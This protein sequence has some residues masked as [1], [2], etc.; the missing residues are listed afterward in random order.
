MSGYYPGHCNIGE[1]ERR[2]RALVAVGAF[3]A[4]GLYVYLCVAGPVPETL[5]VAVFFPLGVGFE[6]GLQAYDAFCV[7]LALLGEYR[8]G[9]ETGEVEV[10]E[11]RHVDQRHAAKLTAAAILLAALSTLAIVLVA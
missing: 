3:L 10:P 11:N 7:R 5:L 8:F 6:W 9:G 1:R 2:R 4:A